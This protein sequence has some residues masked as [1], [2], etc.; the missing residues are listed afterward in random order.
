M[1]LKTRSGTPIKIII[2]TVESYNIPRERLYSSFNNLIDD[3]S[4]IYVYSKHSNSGIH[5]TPKE[6]IKIYTTKNLY[7]YFGF[8]VPMLL[9]QLDSKYS[10]YLYLLIHDTCEFGNQ[11]VEKIID[12]CSEIE[13]EKLDILWLSPNGQSNFC[14]FNHN[15]SLKVYQKLSHFDTL[16]KCFAVKMENEITHP[17]SIKTI[18]NLNMGYMNTQHEH[19]GVSY[20]YSSQRRNTFY[21]PSIDVKKYFVYVEFHHNQVHPEIP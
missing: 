7:E 2:P 17:Y 3:E 20:P 9:S 1:V 8:F 11:S 15:T 21:Y 10:N 13:K 12:I 19:L 14:I 5:I 16:D 18:Q 4:L 6:S